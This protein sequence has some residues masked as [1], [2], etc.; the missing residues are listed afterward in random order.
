M[1]QQSNISKLAEVIARIDRLPVR[2]YPRSWL[3]I[4]GV[5]YFFAFY[6]IL[7]LSF[8]LV[9]PM[10]K[11]LSLTEAL[12]S[13]AVSATLFGYIVGAYVISTSSDYLGRRLGLIVNLGVFSLGSL[14]SALA[15]S[16]GVLIASRFITGMGI[17]SE[18]SIINS[19]MS[20]ITPAGIR[21][22]LTQWAYVAGALGFAL[23]PFIALVLIPISPIGWR[24]MFGLGAV[25]AF[26]AVFLRA[27][28]PE[29]PRWLA[30]KGRVSEAETLVS[31]MERYTERRV[32]SLPPTPPPIPITGL[33]GYPT[34]ELFNRKY[35]VRLLVLTLFWFF[36]YMLAYGVLGFAPYMLVAAGFLF[37]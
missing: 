2:P 29:S 7:T 27:M 10:V 13:A 24:Y 9:S 34:R 12:I 22:R 26:A 37:T 30:V 28:L 19:Y 36:D 16:P 32:G 33:K 15:T 1:S 25:G 11:Q 14:I 21:G 5:G 35:G 6:D 17:G 8:A 31:H 3:V 4:L 23:T 20:E 18:I